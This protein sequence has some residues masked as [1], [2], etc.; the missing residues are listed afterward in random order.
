[1]KVQERN[2]VLVDMKVDMQH[3]AEVMK[4]LAERKHCNVMTCVLQYAPEYRQKHPVVDEK[5]R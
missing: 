5:E 2:H 4:R 1:M 3:Q